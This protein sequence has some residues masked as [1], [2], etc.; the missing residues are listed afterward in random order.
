M[1]LKGQYDLN[2]IAHTISGLKLKGGLSGKICHVLI[3]VALA[4]AAIAWSVQV[5]WVAVLS[6]SMIFVLTMVM[7]WRLINLAD[8]NPQSALMEG[9]EF[10]VHE[11]LQFGTKQQPQMHITKNDM[12]EAG[13]LQLSS[14]DLKTLNQP[15]TPLNHKVLSE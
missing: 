13:P 4:M 10:L 12:A 5:I 1:N 3:F 9:A 11:Q 8:K 7:L 14:V 6:L 2:S 15:E